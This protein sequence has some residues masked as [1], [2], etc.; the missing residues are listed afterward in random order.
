[1]QDYKSIPWESRLCEVLELILGPHETHSV[2]RYI[3][4][5][6][7]RGCE[8]FII[9]SW[10]HAFTKSMQNT[11]KQPCRSVIFECKYHIHFITDS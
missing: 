10:Y 7:Y 4:L 6:L 9:I 2:E 8:H 3:I 1:M 5:L 11:I